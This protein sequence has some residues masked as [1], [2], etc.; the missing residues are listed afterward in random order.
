MSEREEEFKQAY[1]KGKIALERGRYQT[2]IN[3]LEKAKQLINPQSKQGGEVRIWLVNAYQAANQSERAIALCQSLVKHPSPEIRKQSERILYIL[4]APV[5]KRPEE[6][7]TKIPDL[8]QISEDKEKTIGSRP[9]GNPKPRRPRKLPEP[10]PIDPSEIKTKD[11]QFI[12]VALLA[13]L[14]SLFLLG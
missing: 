6:W 7:L 5:L 10:E 4:Q 11:N 13:I 14:A 1:E 3:E 12:W 8:S 2:S 9:A